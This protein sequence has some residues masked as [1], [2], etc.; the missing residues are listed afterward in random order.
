MKYLL[1]VIRDF[2]LSQRVIKSTQ[3]K[4]MKIMDEDWKSDMQFKMT[5]YDAF[6]I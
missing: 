2:Q 5:K 4:L 3:Y 6:C 1:I